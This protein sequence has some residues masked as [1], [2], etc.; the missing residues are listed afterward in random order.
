MT[1]E[2]RLDA[3]GK[4]GLCIAT[5]DV[6][7]HEEWERTWVCVYH[8]AGEQRMLLSPDLRGLIDAAVLD[9]TTEQQNKH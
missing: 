4:Y 9:L 5:H 6:L 7:K 3:I 2:E 1:D 8:V